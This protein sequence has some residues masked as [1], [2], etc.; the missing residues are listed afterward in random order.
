MKIS[1][2][3]WLF[4]ADEG[5]YIYNTLSNA[6]LEIDKDTYS[7]LKHLQTEK[8]EVKKTDFDGEL[9]DLLDDQRFICEND[10]DEFLVYKSMHDAQRNDTAHACITVAPTMD[11]PFR[12]HYCF[13]KKEK[14]TSLPKRSTA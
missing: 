3:T 7:L 5:Y 8:A 1:K 11:C 12:C 9:Y 2:Y 4:P 13:E 6:M 10:R 14:N